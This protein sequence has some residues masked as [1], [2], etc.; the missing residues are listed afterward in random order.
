MHPLATTIIVKGSNKRATQ[1]AVIEF[2]VRAALV[3][4]DTCK[5][6]L[7]PLEKLCS[8]FPSRQKVSCES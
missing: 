2:S 7:W 1:S 8:L 5:K 6:N 4:L 3:G